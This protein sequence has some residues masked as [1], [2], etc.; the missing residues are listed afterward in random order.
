VRQASCNQV[1]AERQ[2][3]CNQVSAERQASCNQVKV[4]QVG[5]PPSPVLQ[6]WAQRYSWWA[7]Y[8]I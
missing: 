7:A 4:W 1:S 8:A 6:P 3:S 5:G 2:A